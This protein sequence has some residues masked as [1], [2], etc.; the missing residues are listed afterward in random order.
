MTVRAKTEPGATPSITA[1]AGATSQWRQNYHNP[2]SAVL[3]KASWGAIL[4]TPNYDGTCDGLK[5]RG[6]VFDSADS[7]TDWFIHVRR[8]IAR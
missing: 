1:A 4:A 6:L 3:P 8:E 7:R 2:R 5:G